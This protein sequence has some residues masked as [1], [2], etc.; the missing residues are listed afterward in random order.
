MNPD[1]IKDTASF[2]N[3]PIKTGDTVF[4]SNGFVLVDKILTANKHDNAELPLVDSAWLSELTV[5]SK[6]GRISKVTPAYFIKDGLAT[7]KTDTV[8]QQNLVIGLQKSNS[9]RVELAIKESS[10]VMRYIT[11]KAYRFPWIN[12]L[13]LG[14]VI[15]VLGFMISL[16]FRIK[17]KMYIV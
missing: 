13:W 5:V 16:Y 1:N 17:S 6:E 11:L 14:T 2:T 4:Y 7:F 8:M 9:G 3:V 10:A 15:M 12:L